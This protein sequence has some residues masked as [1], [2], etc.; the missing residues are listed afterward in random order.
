LPS[1]HDYHGQFAVLVGFAEKAAFHQGCLYHP[2]IIRADADN[3]GAQISRGFRGPVFD[4]QR[5][6]IRG[7]VGRQIA[8]ICVGGWQIGRNRRQLHAGNRVRAPQQFAIKQRRRRVDGPSFFDCNPA[9]IRQG[10]RKGLRILAREDDIGIELIRSLDE[11]QQ[12]VAIV[13]PT[14]YKEILTAASRK[15]ALNG[16]RP[17]SPL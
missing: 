14:A 1:P 11:Q 8:V 3:F 17:V 2:K 9:E 6:V 13:E 10:S 4:G 15:A 5:I 7:A 16:S 12:K